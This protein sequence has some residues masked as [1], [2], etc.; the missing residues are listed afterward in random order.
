[1]DNKQTSKLA[2]DFVAMINEGMEPIDCLN[3]ATSEGIEYSDA[4]WLVSRV[5]KLDFDA[6]L[7][8]ETNY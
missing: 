2:L 7:E 6:V 1:M 5:L 3:Y 4:V 8:M